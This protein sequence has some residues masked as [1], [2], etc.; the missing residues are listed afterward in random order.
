VRKKL[1]VL[2]LVGVALVLLAGPALAAG[3][4]RATYV[5]K[6]KVPYEG[7]KAHVISLS[8]TVQSNEG[9][10]ITVLVG[11]TN[12]AFRSFRGKLATINPAD[13]TTYVW[14][15]RGSRPAKTEFSKIAIND[16]VCVNGLVKSET[17][18]VIDARRIDIYKFRKR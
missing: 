10:Y 5:A 18:Y 1:T 17:N 7:R 12:K 13:S 11:M 14:T 4:D 16:F 15:V 3:S 9:G 6:K 2:I 8:G